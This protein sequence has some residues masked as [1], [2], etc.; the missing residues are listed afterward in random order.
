VINPEIEEDRWNPYV[1]ANATWLYM[2][3]SYAQLG[4]RHQRAQTDVGF[5]PDGAGITPNIDAQSSAIYG[6]VSHRVFG[7]LVASAIASYQMN[8]YDQDGADN[9]TE[10]YFL[11]G[12]NLT[13]EINR[14]L[15]LEAGYNYDWLDSELDD[16]LNEDTR[17]YKRNR[18]YVGVRG[19]Y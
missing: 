15:A 12:I 3:G 17:S 1:D 10:D 7:A 5:V 4:F 14:F 11:A 18:V 9:F 8:D 6:S 13:Y 19:T 2:P 16:E